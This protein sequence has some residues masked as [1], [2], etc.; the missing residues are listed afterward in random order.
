MGYRKRKPWGKA[1]LAKYKSEPWRINDWYEEVS[2]IVIQPY[3][4]EAFTIRLIAVGRGD[5]PHDRL[6][7]SLVDKPD[8]QITLGLQFDSLS[9]LGH[10]CVES[11]Q[12]LDSL[13]ARKSNQARRI[14]TQLAKSPSKKTS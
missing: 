14:Y 11:E 13:K 4:G 5:Y 6:I 10:W 3:G 12:L 7:V 1:P 8:T 2:S 9:D